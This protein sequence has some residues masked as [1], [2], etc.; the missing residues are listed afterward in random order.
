[1]S[2][3]ARIEA[4]NAHALWIDTLGALTQA[5]RSLEAAQ[6]YLEDLHKSDWADLLQ[7]LVDQVSAAE[8]EALEEMRRAKT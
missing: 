8:T 1:M 2:E 5:R 7:P 4:E 6:G 3:D